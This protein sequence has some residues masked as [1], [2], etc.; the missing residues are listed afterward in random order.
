MWLLHCWGTEAIE[1]AG[2]EGWLP[3]GSAGSCF[4][5]HW[6][7]SVSSAMSQP[8]FREVGRKLCTRVQLGRCKFN[9]GRMA[10]RTGLVGA[11]ATSGT[12]RE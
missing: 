1:A 3:A 9:A 8:G 12:G 5:H 7:G 6:L 10:H 4:I 2:L 11:G